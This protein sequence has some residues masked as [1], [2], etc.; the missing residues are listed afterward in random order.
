YDGAF[1]TAHVTE[2]EAGTCTLEPY[3]LSFDCSGIC[4]EYSP[5]IKSIPSTTDTTTAAPD[6]SSFCNYKCFQIS[7]DSPTDYHTFQFLIPYIPSAG[8]NEFAG[9]D[10]DDAAPYASESN[11]ILKKI[12][13]LQLPQATTTVYVLQYL[14]LS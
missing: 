7:K 5:C 13:Q 8:N 3:T 1:A 4:D 6:T 2:T 12:E 10:E 14:A 11:D 9:S